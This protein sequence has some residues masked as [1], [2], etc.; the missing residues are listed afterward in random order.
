MTA[1]SPTGSPGSRLSP[2]L[3]GGRIRGR[4]VLLLRRWGEHGRP[5]VVWHVAGLT[6]AISGMGMIGCALVEGIDGGDDG[7]PLALTGVGALVLGTWIWRGTT[8]PER[9]Q[10][11]DVFAVVTVAWLALATVGAVPYLATGTLTSVH[12]ALFESVS[13]F[14]T[15]GATVLRPIEGNSAGIL[16]WRSLSQWLGGMGVI[17]LVVAVLPSV[18]AGGM[19][20]LA[21]ESPGPTGERLTP[22][23]R[24]TAQ[25]LW[26]VYLGLTVGM[27]VAYAL[28]GMSAYDA[29]AH[30]LTTVSTGGFS[31]HDASIAHF[32]SAA[33]EWIAVGGMF[34][35]GGSFTLYYR[36][37]RG[38]AGPLLRSAEFQLYVLVLVGAASFGYIS[39]A[40]DA[41]WGHDAARESVFTITAIVT[42][43]GYT[44]VD[45]G[46]WSQASQVVLLLLMPVGAMAGS[47]AGGVKL[48]R[49][50]A[51]GS[52]AYRELLRQL[53]P[54]LVR[55][56]HVGA[57]QLDEPVVT[58]VLGFLVLG[59]VIFGLGVVAI[60]LTG[61]DLVTSY[62]ASATAFGNVGPGLGAVGPTNDFGELSAWGRGALEVVML[63][64]RLEIY[65]VL[66][67]VA[68]LPRRWSTRG[69]R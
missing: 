44:T 6:M 20:L 69:R 58:R 16:L 41:G 67:A 65:P 17:V 49:I 24:N 2:A 7:V 55:P 34:L 43:T 15:T 21:A 54:R 37:L 62:G 3:V 39:N 19:D 46:S 4:V 8:V 63:L 14:T 33:I 25:R 52:Y 57:T 5:S 10:R 45:F 13:G 12:D 27:I 64:G 18:R 60:A 31:P 61:E 48:V 22:R 30:S 53:H 32:D 35:A 11:V 38:K 28:A 36:V 68:A 40:G 56:V 66:L 42:T 51:V 59:L 29:L 1:T 26:S 47:T 23:V 9:I 50:L